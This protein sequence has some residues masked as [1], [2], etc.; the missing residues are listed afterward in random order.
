MDLWDAL[1]TGVYNIYF[2]IVIT[3]ILHTAQPPTIP[4]IQ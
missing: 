4:C 3:L 1:Y 2:A